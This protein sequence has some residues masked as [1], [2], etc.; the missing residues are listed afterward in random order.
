MR[1]R[2]GS[3][4]S[5]STQVR[6]FE[7]VG[8]FGHSSGITE[9]VQS[10]EH[11]WGCKDQV[12]QEG[13]DGRATWPNI[14]CH[15][16]CAEAGHAGRVPPRQHFGDY[17]SQIGT[18]PLCTQKGWGRGQAAPCSPGAEQRLSTNSRKGISCVSLPAS[19]QAQSNDCRSMS[20]LSDLFIW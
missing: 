6:L 9:T 17:G 4:H 11:A 2:A 18:A 3:D 1:D 20:E 19:Q 8:W 7:E 16:V 5:H 12:H 14:H 15:P 13:K 10:P